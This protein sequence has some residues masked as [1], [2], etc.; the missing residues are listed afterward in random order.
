MRLLI[1]AVFTLSMIVVSIAVGVAAIHTLEVITA[2]YGYVGGIGALVL[3]I[4]LLGFVLPPLMSF[5][6]WLTGWLLDRA[7]A[8]PAHDSS[9]AVERAQAVQDLP[10]GEMQTWSN[11]AELEAALEVAG[12]G[13]W[14]PRLAELAKHC[15]IFVPGPIE[16][17]AVAPIGASRLGG[18]PDLPPDVDWPLRPPVNVEDAAGPVPGRILLGPHHRL[19]R[20]FRTQDWQ[21]VSRQWE[22]GQ[23]A[24]RDVRRRTWPLSFVAQVDFAEVHAVHA[25]DGFPAAGRLSLFCDPFD[26]PWGARED[27]ARVRAIF[28]EAPALR[29]QRRRAPEEFDE[30]AAREVMPRGYVFSPRILRPT[31]WLLPPPLGS[32]GQPRAWSSP[33]WPGWPAYEQFWRDLYARH[34]E[35]FGPNGEMIHQ[36]GGTA[37]SIQRPVE[38][39][40]VRFAETGPGPDRRRQ[41]HAPTTEPLARASEWQLVLQI[42]SD[43]AV[44]ME[45]G[46]VGRLYLCARKED[47]AARRFDR[48]WMVMQ[49]Y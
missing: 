26:W 25:L 20:L 1:L 41:M 13:E 33:D 44:G 16:E 28:S 36:V 29:L 5:A 46:D 18:A 27:Q 30:P 12:L 14:A 4:A 31:A 10:R 32:A 22:S 37:F 23:Q 45:W 19:H 43:I 15:I 17:A 6:L 34:P 24:E 39:E 3:L 48:C 11:E 2:R 47:L 38:A 9:I 8:Q 49:C 35:T 21:R 42:D 7:S 40:C